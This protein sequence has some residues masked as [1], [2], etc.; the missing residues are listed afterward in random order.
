MHAH[1][2]TSIT[3]LAVLGAVGIAGCGG[4]AGRNA[5]HPARPVQL[6]A[7]TTVANTNG[8]TI[9]VAGH[10]KVEGTP[11]TVT[12]TIG[13]Q[14]T[15]PSAQTAMQKNG[16][17]ATALIDALKSRGVAAKDIQTNDLSVSPT[18]DTKGQQITGYSVSNPVSVRLHDI[19][20]AGSI[21]DAAAAKVGNDVR[22]QGVAFSIEDPTGA[23]AQAR[24]AAVKDAITQAQ[25]LAAAAGVKLG[26][27]RSIDDTGTQ[28]PQP[29]YFTGTTAGDAVHASTPVEPGSQQLA[30]DVSVV[31]D[32]AT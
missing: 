15:D 24:A 32:I 19:T 22:L 21:I 27:I 23:L 11:D 28:L 26:A 4:A 7:A 13:V 31:Y 6:A 30:V 2:R 18:W 16:D 8:P 14:T 20:H 10:G 3:A 29:Q 17:E 9:S 12:V 5:A 25:Q 1:K